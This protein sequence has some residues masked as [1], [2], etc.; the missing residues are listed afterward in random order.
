M[1]VLVVIPCYLPAYGY[2][3]PVTAVHELCRRLAALGADVTVATTNADG[4]GTLAVPTGRTVLMD[5]VKV[6]YFPVSNTFPFFYSPELGTFLKQ[7]VRSFDLVHINWLYA[8]STVVAARQCLGQGVPYI[9]TPHGMLDA[10]AVRM[11]GRLKKI[12]FLGLIGRKCLCGAAAVHFT[13]EGERTN[14]LSAGWPVRPLVL[15]NGIDISA[16]GKPADG[17]L[18]LRRFP[19]LAGK[20]TVLFLG[21]MNYIKGLDLLSRAWPL[22]VAAAPEAHLVLAGPDSDDYGR[23]VRGWLAEGGVEDKA[24]FTGLLLGA[25]KAAALSLADVFVSSSYLESFGMAI[26]EAMACGKPVVVTDRVNICPE[27]RQAGAGL[28][29]GC[30]A[31]EIAGAIAF[32]LANSAAG[33]EMGQRGRK[34]VEE[35]FTLERSAEEM[36]HAYADILDGRSAARAR[37]STL[38]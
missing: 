22:V 15:H 12:L 14:A 4:N 24:T 1:N 28:I 11:K 36:F 6:V 35:N 2:G 30:E 18:L 27:I 5:G 38:T 25:E 21:R 3:G 9:I 37:H 32:L 33:I 20:K 10:R 7:R 23:R 26:V 19:E 34:L 17:N 13:S 8:Y 16:Y 31:G 29:T